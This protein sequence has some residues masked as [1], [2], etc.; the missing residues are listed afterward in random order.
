MIFVVYLSIERGVSIASQGNLTDLETSNKSLG[1]LFLYFY[2]LKTGQMT[3]S[4]FNATAY[5]SENNDLTLLEVAAFITEVY[6]TE[7]GVAFMS[8][9]IASGQVNL[10]AKG[11]I[12]SQF[13]FSKSTEGFAYWDSIYQSIQEASRRY[14]TEHGLSQGIGCLSS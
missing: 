4:L 8:N 13:I 11:T 10:L 1:Q 6:G 7:E 3:T 9:V 2:K 12:S 14:R 5:F